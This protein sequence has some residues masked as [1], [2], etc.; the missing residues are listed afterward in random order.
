MRLDLK[1]AIQWR[2]EITNIEVILRLANLV[3]TN[4]ITAGRGS[5]TG[6]RRCH[7]LVTLTNEFF[8]TSHKSFKNE[9]FISWLQLKQKLSELKKPFF[10]AGFFYRLCYPIQIGSH[11]SASGSWLSTSHRAS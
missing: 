11:F 2:D 7:A 6:L 8:N 5:V 4:L 9:N 10:L 3:S 1:L